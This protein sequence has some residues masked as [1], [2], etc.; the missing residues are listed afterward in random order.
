MIEQRVSD[1]V[2]GEDSNMLKKFTFLRLASPGFVALGLLV[3]P[4]LVA[5]S[6]VAAEL[7]VL[8]VNQAA[9][10]QGSLVGKDEGRKLQVIMEAIAADEKAE[11]EPIAKEAQELQ[12]QRALL[13]DDFARKQMELQRK[14][15]Y[16]KYK[17]DQE[18]K[19]TQE[20][21]QR[22]I[23]QKVYP[24]FNEIMKEKK[25][26]LL[27]DQSQVIMTSPDFNI[28]EEVIKKLD[29]RMPTVDVIRVTFAQIQKAFEEQQAQLKAAQAAKK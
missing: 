19:Y 29:A 2:R 25:G 8:V 26:T 4:A 11:M 12:S 20:G 17:Y 1:L 21:A 23:I 15:E 14:A 13:G 9:I 27:L 24:I 22:Q 28:T 3:L 7:K 10:F 16:I 5:T 18:R 6:A